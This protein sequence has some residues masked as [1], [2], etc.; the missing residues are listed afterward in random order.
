M[1]ARTRAT[2]R[3]LRDSAERSLAYLR[4]LE[5]RPVFPPAPSLEALGQFPAALPDGPSPPEAVLDLLDR[6]GS[7]ATVASNDGRYF[8]FVVGSTLPAALAANWLA[9]AWNQN[10]G[11]TV[12]SPVAA[13]LERLA[14]RWIRELLGLPEGADGAFVTGTSI[15]N[16]VGLAAARHAVLDRV[17]YDV[18][19]KGMSGSPPVT[20]VVGEEAHVTVVKALS[21]LGFG[22]DRVL[23][24]PVD[25]QGR[26]RP[27]AIPP[28][29]PPA[30]VCLQAGNVNTGAI[31]PM[32]DIIPQAKEQ[33]AW[34]HV[35][36]AF[37]LWAAAAR[38]RRHLIP[39]V[40]LADSWATDGHKWLNVPYD[41]GVVLVR[42]PEFLTAAM[43]TGPAAY[44][45]TVARHEPGKFTPELSRRA[46]GVEAWAAIASLGKSGVDAM[47][48]RCCQL[49]A[50]FADRLRTS[51][52]S[53]LNDVTLNQVLVSFGDD[54]T[55]ERVISAV[56]ADG[57]CW[58]GGTR[59]H[60]RAA[61][62]ISVSSCATTEE[63]VDRSLAA[64]LRI[65][66]EGRAEG[67][68]ARATRRSGLQ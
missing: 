44:L 66:G 10:A 43:S 34:V 23:R 29:K 5:D 63:D 36:G 13:H 33:D 37:G 50:R 58:C 42:S 22:R 49:A 14:I 17:G 25:D 19:G 9:A 21:M 51:G 39:G 48:E 45:A 4:G 60:G 6:Y 68:P 3:L 65:A 57:T 8:G 18:E 16:F 53:I 46:R 12:L 35:D 31:D 20:V 27:E 64:I 24:V 2:E 38:S 56:Q 62:R 30:I 55:T 61:M 47:I 59:W 1:S 52:Y 26:L 7:P 15:A 54:P 11:L 40:E 67:K 41:S 32:A 28:L